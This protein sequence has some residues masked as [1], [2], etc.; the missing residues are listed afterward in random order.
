MYKIVLVMKNIRNI[1]AFVFVCMSVNQQ[2]C[3]AQS[4]HSAISSAICDG[5]SGFQ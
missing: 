4:M 1:A 2:L 3:L 5:D